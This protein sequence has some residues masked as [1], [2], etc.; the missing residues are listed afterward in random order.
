V[1]L[2]YPSD[3]EGDEVMIDFDD[4]SVMTFQPSEPTDEEMESCRDTRVTSPI[5]WA[6]QEYFDMGEEQPFSSNEALVY[7]SEM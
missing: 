1:L 4:N 6:P 5:T 2:K 7:K 3:A